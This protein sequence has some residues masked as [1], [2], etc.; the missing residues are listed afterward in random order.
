MARRLRRRLAVADTSLS[1]CDAQR[2][3]RGVNRL[4]TTGGVLILLDAE[5]ALFNVP[6]FNVSPPLPPVIPAQAGIQVFDF[7]WFFVLKAVDKK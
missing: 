3:T 5:D 6:Q 2:A 7:V 4:G 1:G